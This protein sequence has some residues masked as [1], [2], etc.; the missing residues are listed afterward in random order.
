M[1]TL[2]LSKQLQNLIVLAAEHYDGPRGRHLSSK[3][4]ADIEVLAEHMSAVMYE[5]GLCITK[6]STEASLSKLGE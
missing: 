1:E 4:L 5:K 3:E 2:T 6:A